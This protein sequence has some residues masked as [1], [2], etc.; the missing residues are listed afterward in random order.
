MEVKPASTGR[1]ASALTQAEALEG[2]GIETVIYDDVNLIVQLEENITGLQ[3]C[4]LA[5]HPCEQTNKR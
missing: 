5:S 1:W 3:H 4:M 2:E